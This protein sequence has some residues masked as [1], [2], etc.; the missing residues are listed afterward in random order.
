MGANY[1]FYV[2]FIAPCVPTFFGYI[3]LVLANVNRNYIQ[4]YFFSGVEVDQ[5]AASEY[6]LRVMELMAM[7]QMKNTMVISNS[8]KRKFALQWELL[9]IFFF[10]LSCFECSIAL[11]YFVIQFYENFL[12]GPWGFVLSEEL[13]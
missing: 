2:K 5:E 8:F 10:F 7:V 11:L 3:I 13:H 9:G 12:F 6:L 4:N 1:S